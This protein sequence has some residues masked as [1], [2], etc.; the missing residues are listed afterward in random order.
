MK[1]TLTFLA[2]L[3]TT[4]TFAQGTW[5]PYAS[6]EENIHISDV[7]PSYNYINLSTPAGNAGMRLG[8]FYT[9][10]SALSAEITL[11]VVGIG[12]PG[13]FSNTII[14]VEAVGHYN[15]LDGMDV[16]MPSKFNIDLGVGS[17]L[18]ES[19][20]GNFGFSEHLVVG[21]S[22]ELADVVPFGTLIMGTRYTAFIDDYIDGMTVSGSSNDGVLRFYTAVRLDGVGKKAKQ[23]MADAEALANRVSASLEKS[24]AEKAAIQKELKAAKNAHAREKAALMDEIEALKAAPAPEAPVEEE[25]VTAEPKGF[26][27][28]IGSY[29]TRE[30]ADRFI[31]DNGSDFTVSYVEDL[32]TY[33]VVFSSHE[34]L[35]DA[36]TSLEEAKAIIETAWIAVY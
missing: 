12:T 34:S 2:T 36:R 18:A 29:P 15:I 35:D 1:K 11:G 27:V 25:V 13:R 30:A 4:L 6:V 33:R 8:A 10:N 28:I 31:A 20:N 16:K 24:E 14:P 3:A 22:M 19:S 17:G 23:A 5:A 9:H 7:R 32:D 26:Y 21:A